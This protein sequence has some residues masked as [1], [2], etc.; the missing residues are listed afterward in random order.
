MS[1]EKPTEE[2]LN[3]AK[4]FETEIERFRNSFK[5]L[6]NDFEIDQLI[7]HYTEFATDNNN[8][9]VGNNPNEIK[10]FALNDRHGEYK[11][12]SKRV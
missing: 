11:R 6:K 3:N 10:I 7:Q 2:Q 4:E 5:K 8:F 12:K 1:E 9:R